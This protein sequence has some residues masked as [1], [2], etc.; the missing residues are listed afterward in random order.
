MTGELTAQARAFAKREGVNHV[1]SKASD[2][3]EASLIFC[4]I[5]IGNG[6]DREAFSRCKPGCGNN[7]G[8]NLIALC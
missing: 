3:E 6:L 5:G 2:S 1:I 4:Y 7:N 8:L